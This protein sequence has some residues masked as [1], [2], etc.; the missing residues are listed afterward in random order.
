MPTLVQY[1]E[2]SNIKEPKEININTERKTVANIKKDLDSLKL[3][4]HSYDSALTILD[5]YKDIFDNSKNKLDNF[6]KF[7][8]FIDQYRK[9]FS[10]NIIPL[11]QDNAQLVFNTLT[12]DKFNNFVIKKDYSIENYDDLSGS[13]AD[14]ASLAIRM[15]IAQV[16]RIGTFQSVILD[17]VAASFDVYKENLLLELLKTTSNQIIYISHGEIN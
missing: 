7:V 11:I 14:C 15:A 8:K 10:Q 16:S 13:E 17:E 12:E 6:K 9:E 5:T 4:K 3:I 1:E 2:L